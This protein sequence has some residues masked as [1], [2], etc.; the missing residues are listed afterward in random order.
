[1]TGLLPICAKCK[2]IRD[3]K[4]YWNQVE[5]YISDHSEAVFSHGICEECIDKLYGA[6][7]WY[8]KKIKDKGSN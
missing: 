7:D 4:G 5:K 8:N 2:K 6:H 3:E 1:M